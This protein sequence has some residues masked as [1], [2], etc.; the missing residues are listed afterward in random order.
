LG[1]GPG[2]GT[3]VNDFAIVNK[4]TLIK[5][6]YNVTFVT[7]GNA[8]TMVIADGK[9]YSFGWNEFG[10]LGLGDINVRY[11]PTLIPGL[12]NL[13]VS[14][15]SCGSKH[16]AVIADELL[17]TFGN[18]EKGELGLGDRDPR[19]VPTLVPTLNNVMYVSCGFD[20]TAV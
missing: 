12:I 11:Y 13:N 7:C 17:Y 5:D 20:N 15:I 14:Y 16:T 10:Q 9:I 4:P 1:L 18:N 19:L 8:H 6:L 2:V 3:I